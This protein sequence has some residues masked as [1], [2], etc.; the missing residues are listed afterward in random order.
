MLATLIGVL[1]LALL[2]AVAGA[3]G[4]TVK[5]GEEYLYLDAEQFDDIGGWTIDSQFRQQMG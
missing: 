3:A 5:P 1:L 2:A 4:D